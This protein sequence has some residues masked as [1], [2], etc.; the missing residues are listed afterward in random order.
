MPAWFEDDD[1]WQGLLPVLFD[2]ERIAA[3]VGEIDQA[4]RLLGSPP[5]GAAILDLCCGPGRHSLE[6]ARRGY[7]PVGV[8]RTAAYLELARARAAQEGLE[9]GF[10][11]SDMRAFRREAAFDGAIN[12]FTSFGYSGNRDDDARV[13]ANLYASLRPGA[14]LLVQLMGK[15]VLARAF[16]PR[17]W[18]EYPDGSLLLEEREMLDG[19]ELIRNRWILLRGGERREFVFTHRLYSGTEIRELL[20]GAGFR[21][22]VL[23]GSLDGRPYD[24][25]ASELAAV[26]LR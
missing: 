25:R 26:A 4:I 23:Y 16:E 10:V 3:A 18:R 7:R 11:L 13:A 22:V 20:E 15:E 2:P 24:R 5:P 19:W 12:L 21:G 8:D 1:F 6:L 9:A 14:R 17:D